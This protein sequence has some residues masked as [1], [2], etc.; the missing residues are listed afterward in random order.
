MRVKTAELNGV[1]LDLA[2]AIAAGHE[3]YE[4]CGT[5]RCDTSKSCGFLAIGLGYSP[6]TNWAQ[7]GPLI[8]RFDPEERRLASGERYAEVWHDDPANEDAFVG[9]GSGNTRL[10]AAC[11]AI[12][13]AKLG[14]EIDLPEGLV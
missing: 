2:V 5:W 4:D 9:K 7:G 12:V 3:V 6:S 10:I 13:A 14:E 8:D 1:A 11:R